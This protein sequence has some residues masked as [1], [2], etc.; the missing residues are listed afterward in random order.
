[1]HPM[2]ALGIVLLAVGALAL[3]FGGFTYAKE[4]HVAQIGALEVSVEDQRTV[5]VPWWLG[6][7]AITTG[8]VLLFGVHKSRGSARS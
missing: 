4:S 1:M 2:K 7:I 8:A 6:A 3:A 5:N